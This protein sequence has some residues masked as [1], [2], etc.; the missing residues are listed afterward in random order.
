MSADILTGQTV[1]NTS[2]NIKSLQHILL[3]FIPLWSLQDND[4]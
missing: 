4:D 2:K 3:A 1:H